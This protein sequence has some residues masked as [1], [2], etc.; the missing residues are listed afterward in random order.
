MKKQQNLWIIGL[1]LGNNLGDWTE[2]NT[3]A[4]EAKYKVRRTTHVSIVL[5]YKKNGNYGEYEMLEK[6]AN[7]EEEKILLRIEMGK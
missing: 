5:F 6:E 3:I 7:G 1:L 2:T 4:F